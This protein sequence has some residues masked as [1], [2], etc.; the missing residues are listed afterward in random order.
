MSGDA[1]TVNNSMF[2]TKDEAQNHYKEIIKQL[3][4]QYQKGRS[5]DVMNEAAEGILTLSVNP[6]RVQ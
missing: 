2:F 1:L 5:K 3:L 6:L 4:D